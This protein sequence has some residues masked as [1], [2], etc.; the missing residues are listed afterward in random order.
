MQ[1]MFRYVVSL[2][3]F[4]LVG[5]V[6]AQDIVDAITE[7]GDL[8]FEE[9]TLQDSITDDCRAAVEDLLPEAQNN[10]SSRLIALGNEVDGSS[11]HIIYLQGIGA[12]GAILEAADYE[13]VVVTVTTDG[14]ETVLEAG[15]YAVDLL[16]DASG[17]LASISFVTDYSGSMAEG[18][19][20]DAADIFEDV[21]DVLPTIFEG[22]VHVFSETVTERQDFTEDQEALLEALVRDDDIE[23]SSTALYDGMGTALTGLVS[24]G[25]PIKILMVGTDGLENASVDFTKDQV[26]SLIEDDHILVV[27]IGT[28]FSDVT[29]LQ[30]LA[31]D[32]GIFFYA[33]TYLEARQQMN[34]FFDSLDN[35]VSLTLDEA[36]ENADSVE[37]EVGGLS[38]DV[39]ME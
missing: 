16:E 12:D 29:E 13:D 4:P 23:R 1:R 22:S 3:L 19:I 5:C 34:D 39:T 33:Q 36:Y 18:D 7:C 9:V 15:E 20:D 24:R 38:L 27:M 37:I 35:T 26:M 10:F 25:R 32:L 21:V 6:S 30:D 31:G 17:D 28:L 11:R 14:V 2:C 8:T